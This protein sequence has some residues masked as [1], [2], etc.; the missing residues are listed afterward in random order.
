MMR[1]LDG[2]CLCFFRVRSGVKG[3]GF[4]RGH[5]VF[6]AVKIRSSLALTCSN[7]AHAYERRTQICRLAHH[8]G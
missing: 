3:Q 1:V 6:G 7:H 2:D 8:N 4:E 5:I